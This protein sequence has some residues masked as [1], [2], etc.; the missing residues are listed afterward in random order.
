MNYLS[1]LIDEKINQPE[2]NAE[3]SMPDNNAEGSKPIGRYSDLLQKAEALIESNDLSSAR[4]VLETVLL[5]EDGNIDALNDL[6][7]IEIMEKNY[8]AA[9]E[10]L[11]KVI[12]LEPDNEVANENILYLQK[13]LDNL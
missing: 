5:L 1:R 6:S 11:E 13:E 9:V 7:V 8:T 10:M 2:N 4:K 12:R 3:Y